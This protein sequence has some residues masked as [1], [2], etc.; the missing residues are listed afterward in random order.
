[1]FAAAVYQISVP[2]RQPFNVGILYAPAAQLTPWKI[3]DA[4]QRPVYPGQICIRAEFQF[5]VE[6]EQTPLNIENPIIVYN[7]NYV[8]WA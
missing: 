7:G 4:V 3:I 6:I 5:F 8:S 2:Y 1:M